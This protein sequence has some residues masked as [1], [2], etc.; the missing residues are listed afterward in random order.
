MPRSDFVTLEVGGRRI[1][2]WTEYAVQSDLLTPADG[3]HLS[4]ALPGGSEAAAAAGRELLDLLEA[5]AEV[6]LFVGLDVTGA[7]PSRAL[8]L[9]G[10]IDEVTISGD[11]GGSQVVVDG[12]DRAAHLCDSSAALTLLRESTNFLTIVREAVSPWSIEVIAD[13]TASRDILTGR[14]IAVPLDRRV[15]EEARSA[16]IPAAMYSRILARRAARDGVPADTLAGVSPT[17]D[18]RALQANGMAPGDI[19]RLQTRAAKPNPGE[20]VWDFLDRH[21]KRLGLLMW[22][23]PKGRLVLS[24]PR[25][26]QRPL[27][28]IVRRRKSRESDPNNVL[29]GAVSR[30]AADRY[31]EVTV[32]GRG[33]GADLT[34]SAISHTERDSTFPH[35]RP[36]VV[37]DSGARTLAEVQRRARRELNRY[38]ANALQAS[39]LVPDHGQRGFLYATDTIATVVDEV[40]GLEQDMYLAKRTFRCDRERGTLT[41]LTLMAKGAIVL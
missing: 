25:Y 39:Y 11:R 16:G 40:C 41:E 26:E 35:Y 4:F 38:K 20:T 31:S 36:L 33:G 2:T 24:A 21:A 6:K 10:V 15:A 3:F 7:N 5:G 34:R 29:E 27:Y 9:T 37:H 17:A 12:R 22:M 1:D 30:N 8:Q 32:Y 23:D 19:E 14:A 18:S 28:R 13:H